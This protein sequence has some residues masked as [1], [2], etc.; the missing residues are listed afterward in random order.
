MTN[1]EAAFSN[2]RLWESLGFVIAF[3]YSS[4]LCTRIKLGVLTAML[5]LGMLGYIYIEYQ[6]YPGSQEQVGY[7]SCY[8]KW[9]GLSR[10]KSWSMLTWKENI[11][12]FPTVTTSSRAIW[13]DTCISFL[14]VIHLC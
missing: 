14:I 12:K 13:G 11:I 1:S 8:F 3:A 2:Y 10:M 7:A 4:Y 6:V 9:P 5:L